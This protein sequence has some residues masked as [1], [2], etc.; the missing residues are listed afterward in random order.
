[1]SHWPGRAR[2]G[3][4]ELGLAQKYPGGAVAVAVCRLV[5]GV[6]EPDR[7]SGRN[8]HGPRCSIPRALWLC[9]GRGTPIETEIR[10]GQT[11]C[12]RWTKTK[13]SGGKDVELEDMP[14]R[15]CVSE[16]TCRRH[17]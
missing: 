12:I 8:A 17:G 16:H 4:T 5:A 14:D 3:G 2:C 15:A 13:H 11:C 6:P 10:S 9:P 1:N 7:R